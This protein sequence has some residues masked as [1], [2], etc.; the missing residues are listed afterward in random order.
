MSQLSLL[1]PHLH[2]ALAEEINR[3]TTARRVPS[4]VFAEPHGGDGKGQAEQMANF[5]AT[6][7][8]RVTAALLLVLPPVSIES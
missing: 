6:Q 3:V 7:K 4:F 1:F 5:F 2:L 8:D